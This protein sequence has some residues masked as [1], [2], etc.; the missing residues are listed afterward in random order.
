MPCPRAAQRGRKRRRRGPRCFAGVERRAG[1]TDSQQDHSYSR[2]GSL[3]P[4]DASLW[5]PSAPLAF[6]CC[7]AGAFFLFRALPTPRVI[8]DLMYGLM[9]YSLGRAAVGQ[10][11]T[12]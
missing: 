9:R 5:P 11:R 8:S 3:L 4:E 10:T 2:A 7:F 1:R 12:R 6:G